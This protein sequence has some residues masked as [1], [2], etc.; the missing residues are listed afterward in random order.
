MAG[1]MEEVLVLSR[2]EAGKMDFKPAPIDLP[3]FCRRLTDE[4]LSATEH[5]CPI[6]LVS[7][8]LPQEASADDRLLRH[9]FTN[10]LTNAVKYSPAGSPVEFV[11]EREEA[12]LVCR[13]RDRGIGISE[14]DRERLFTALHRGRNVGNTPGTGLGLTIVRR[15]LEVNGGTIEVESTLGK[16]TTMIVRLPVFPRSCE[17]ES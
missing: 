1:L 12:E 13:I 7:A 16:G 14:A 3:M 8:S 15:C 4:V 9:V 5:K 11:I 10:L 17:L 6:A 2:V